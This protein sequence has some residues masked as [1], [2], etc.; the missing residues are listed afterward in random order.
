MTKRTKKL[1]TRP[2]INP[3][4][5]K[6]L[7]QQAEGQEL[8]GADGFFQSL[9]QSLANGILDGEMEHHLGYQKH[10]KSP[11][12]TTNRRNGHYAKTV[13]SDD[14][15][16][17]LRIPRDRDNDY[18]PQFIPKNARRFDG[19][20]DKVISMYARGMTMREIQQYIYEIYGTEVSHELIS[21]V[22]DKVIDDINA[23]QNRPLNSIYPIVYLDCMHIKTRDTHVIINK[24]VYLAV[25]INMEGKKE[26]LG[27]WIAKTE[28]AKFWL[29]VITELKNRGVTD[30]FIACIDGLTGFEDAICSVFPQTTVQLC[31]V[32][33]VRNSLKFVPWKDKKQVADDL[34]AIYNASSE[35]MALQQLKA[36]R[37]KWDS[38]YPTI[39]NSWQKKWASIAPCLAYPEHIK[40]VIY[41]TNTIESINRQ[42]R[43]IIKNKGVFPNDTAVKKS[44]F[45]ALQNAEKRWTMPIRNWKQA[46]NQFAIMFDDRV[47]L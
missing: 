30:I 31:I 47:K 34:K 5:I 10:D 16:L 32:H 44:L 22:T 35:D 21:T 38:T 20:D 12:S 24:A 2:E 28:G 46:L 27:M 43:K 17:N 33:M 7:L 25:G 18:E 40:K 29:Q 42:I 8:F 13:I 9:K 4:L 1:N 39:A 11:K 19:F 41:T 6:Q 23:W 36:F 15:T 26:V 3:D 14:D 37:Q 45:L